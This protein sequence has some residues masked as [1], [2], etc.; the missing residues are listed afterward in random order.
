MSSVLGRWVK[1]RDGE[2]SNENLVGESRGV[3]LRWVGERK[4]GERGFDEIRVD[5]FGLITSF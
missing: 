3:E 5:V 4:R 2:I 1:R